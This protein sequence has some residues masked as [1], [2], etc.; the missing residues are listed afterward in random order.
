MRT[1]SLGCNFALSRK[2]PA[3]TAKFCELSSTNVEDGRRE[4]RDF[5]QEILLSPPYLG[6]TAD[7]QGTAGSE[8]EFQNGTLRLRKPT[9]RAKTGIAIQRNALAYIRDMLNGPESLQPAPEPVIA[10]V[11]LIALPDRV[12]VSTNW[13]TPF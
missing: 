9:R 6:F 11:P 10:Q 3:R 12:P 13:L 4:N 5:S 8:S 7:R 2:K 1:L